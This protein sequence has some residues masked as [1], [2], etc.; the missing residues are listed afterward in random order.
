MVEL[1]LTTFQKKQAIHL[2][3]NLKFGTFSKSIY[4]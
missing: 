3:L 4:S 1:E 2:Q